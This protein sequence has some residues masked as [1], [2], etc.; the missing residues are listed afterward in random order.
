MRTLTFPSHLVGISARCCLYETESLS[1][2]YPGQTPRSYDSPSVRRDLVDLYFPI[3]PDERLSIIRIRKEKKEPNECLEVVTSRGR[4][5][6]FGPNP[7]YEKYDY[8][9]VYSCD[10][11]QIKTIFMTIR[12]SKERLAFGV[13]VERQSTD[14][15]AIGSTE[16]I[17]GPIRSSRYYG[18]ILTEANLEGLMHY[19]CRYSYGFESSVVQGV[20][21]TTMQG[22]YAI[23][24][25]QWDDLVSAPFD[26]RHGL[27][28]LS[29]TSEY[30]I[31]HVQVQQYGEE[32]AEGELA[33]SMHKVLWW[34]GA[35]GDR[36]EI[37][38]RE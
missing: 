26:G 37:L 33:T 6:C 27:R 30:G 38:S 8:H 10:Q 20:W 28:F 9:E 14:S 24:Q 16:P 1:L 21:L 35:Q 3:W 12:S 4:S 25:W 11:G 31:G 36:V 18:D 7:R 5:V 13:V 22:D 23:G 2:H 32:K 17:Q 15:S 19:R 29:Q 34:I